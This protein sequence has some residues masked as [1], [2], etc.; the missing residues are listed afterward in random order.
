MSLASEAFQGLFPGKELQHEFSIR[1]SGKFKGYNANVY[2]KPGWMEF[3]LS[4][5]WR[6]VSR[7]IRIG[8]IQCLMLKVLR[9][10]ANTI[11]IDLYNIFLKKAHQVQ[12]GRKVHPILAESFNRVNEKYFAG[13]MEMPSLR[14]GSRSVRKLGSYEYGSDSIVISSALKGKDFLTD[15]VMYHEML[16]KK[17]KYNVKNGRSYHH[18]RQ[19]REAERLFEGQEEAERQLKRLGQWRFLGISFI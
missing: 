4:K 11:N 13:M 7:D 3:R 10:Q 1:Y 5:E 9:K 19:F 18:T 6:G 17:F 14:F 15:Y 16:H 8:L 2:Y 12:K